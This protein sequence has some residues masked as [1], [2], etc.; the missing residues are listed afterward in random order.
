MLN[1]ENILKSFVYKRRLFEAGTFG[2]KFLFWTMIPEYSISYKASKGIKVQQAE[3][4]YPKF[5]PKPIEQIYQHSREA[6][7][8][9]FVEDL[10]DIH[11]AIDKIKSKKSL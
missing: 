11:V 4:C 2:P 6:F 3:N 5:L 8:R 7:Q 1:L 9:I 10:Q